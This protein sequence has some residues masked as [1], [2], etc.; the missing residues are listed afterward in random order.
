MQDETTTPYGYCQCGCGQLAPRTPQAIKKLGLKKGEP[1]RF[2]RNHQTRLPRPPYEGDGLCE[3][4][5]GELTQVATQPSPGVIVGHSRRF[6]HGHANRQRK[7]HYEV[8]DCGHETPCWV[9]VLT[10]NE[11]G[12]GHAGGKAHRRYYERL[13]GPIPAGLELD[14]LCNVRACVNPDHLEP[15]THADN[16]RRAIERRMAR[17]S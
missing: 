3:C 12:Y 2:V 1:Y 10:L 6:V 14:H 5:C 9:W 8:R 16:I 13:V 17:R 7:Q 4:G 15:V 11:N